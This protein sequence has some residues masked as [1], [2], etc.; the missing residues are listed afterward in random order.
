MRV[1][2]KQPVVLVALNRANAAADIEALRGAGVTS[3]EGGTGCYE[4][5]QEQCYALPIEQ[6]TQQ[7]K[8][9]LKECNQACVMYLDNQYN[10][11][12]AYGENN[13]AG[14]NV[15]APE[16][17]ATYVGEF[18]SSTQQQAEKAKS[19]TRFAG[20]YYVARK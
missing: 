15:S 6:F 17:M 7:V 14:Y 9:L 13:Y 1:N 18:K 3:F 5:K 20:Q 10:A 4:G 8:D 16:V 19:W 11:W 2:G 12:L